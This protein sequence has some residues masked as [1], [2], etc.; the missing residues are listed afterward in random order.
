ML[1]RLDAVAHHGE[2]RRAHE[3]FLGGPAP[4]RRLV[5]LTPPACSA[6]T[7]SIRSGRS[8]ARQLLERGCEELP[9]TTGSLHARALVSSWF[10]WPCSS[11]P[12]TSH[13]SRDR[14]VRQPT[15]TRSYRNNWLQSESERAILTHRNK[16][17][18]LRPSSRSRGSNER[19]RL[20]SEIPQNREARR[21]LG[22]VPHSSCKRLG[23]AGGCPRRGPRR[24][25]SGG[26][27]PA[28]RHVPRSGRRAQ[29][30]QSG[31][32]WQTQRSGAMPR[33]GRRSA[34][35]CRTSRRAACTRAISA[36]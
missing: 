7:S 20:M 36:R 21:P 15:S 35:S 26:G 16:E 18:R 1:G 30:G 32:P 29:P 23:I 31:G 6:A 8:H 34:G 5:L 4:G 22:S 2:E 9:R 10:A 12:S 13:P 27:P 28:A 19:S 11:S 24:G 3:I 14:S 17:L 25:V 33:P